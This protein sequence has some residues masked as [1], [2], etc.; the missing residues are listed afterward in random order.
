MASCPECQTT[1]SERA[2]TCPYCGFCAVDPTRSIAYEPA[3]SIPIRWD[4]QTYKVF[5]NVIPISRSQEQEI[6]SAFSDASEI[7]RVAPAVYNFIQ[8]LHPEKMLVAD[9][10]PAMKEMLEAGILK[11]QITENG[12]ILGH[13][14]K[15]G[16]KGINQVVRLKEVSIAQNLS[17]SLSHL[18]MQLQ[19]AEIGHS[20]KVLHQEIEH[21]RR[22]ARNDRLSLVECAWQELEQATRLADGRRREEKLMSLQSTATLGKV[23]LIHEC[24]EQAAFFAQRKGDGIFHKVFDSES[25]KKGTIYSK[26]IFETLASLL[27][28]FRIEY[29]VY[30]VLGEQEAAK[31]VLRQ[32]YTFME[33]EKLMDR[34]TLLRWNSY[35]DPSSAMRIEKHFIPQITALGNTLQKVIALPPAMPSLLPAPISA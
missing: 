1:I 21:L 8:A 3:N 25:D 5:D 4:A 7:A 29:N 16:E 23:R 18:Q 15:D 12:E 27:L 33:Q 17:E 20:I 10:T 26:E 31:T 9:L 11:F 35:A 19:L 34:N 28:A 30:L 24:S 32:V 14:I 13:I 6:I 22:G 2:R